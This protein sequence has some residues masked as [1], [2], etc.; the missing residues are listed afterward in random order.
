MRY[1][2]ADWRQRP[3]TAPTSGVGQ[4]AAGCLNHPL[5]HHLRYYRVRRIDCAAVV[6][7]AGWEVPSPPAVSM[8]PDSDSSP[9]R[10][11]AA[12]DRCSGRD[13]TS[14]D[15]LSDTGHFR[16][17]CSAAVVAAAAVGPAGY[18]VPDR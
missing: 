12:V 10:T 6:A 2:L 1:F 8:G 11:V 16:S 13:W 14:I 4:V 7:T 15:F 9:G 5:H 18:T 3:L 17:P